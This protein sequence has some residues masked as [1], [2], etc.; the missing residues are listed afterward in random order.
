MKILTVFLLSAFTIIVPMISSATAVGDSSKFNKQKTVEKITVSHKSDTLK[1]QSNANTNISVNKQP[2]LSLNGFEWLLVFSPVILF[3]IFII[4]ALAWLRNFK[5]NE[6]LTEND[7]SKTT[8]ANP[9]YT[10]NNINAALAV[11]PTALIANIIPPTIDI[12]AGY[13]P[14]MS[15]LIAFITSILSL[16]LGLTLSCFV[17][18]NNLMV[19]ATPDITDLSKVLLSLGIGIVP[20]TV[21]KISSAISK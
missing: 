21:N 10:I 4:P 19:K 14:S 20:Y 18:Y 15:R 13:R 5:L 12:S 17:I 8:I 11:S 16:I 1:K 2:K 9:Q 7:L 6:A 3:F